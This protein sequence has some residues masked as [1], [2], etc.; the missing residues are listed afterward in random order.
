MTERTIVLPEQDAAL[1]ERL[2]E[3]GGYADTTEALHDGLGLAGLPH[4]VERGA[5]YGGSPGSRP[6]RPR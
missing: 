1:L 4:A 6:G 5:A 3:S 2:V